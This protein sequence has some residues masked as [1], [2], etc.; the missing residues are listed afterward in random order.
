M[1][2]VARPRKNFVVLRVEIF[3]ATSILRCRPIPTYLTQ[4][5]GKLLIG[6]T[7]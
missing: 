4:H 7:S 6:E 2:A 3:N 1:S 5:G